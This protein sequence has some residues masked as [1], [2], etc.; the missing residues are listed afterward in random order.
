MRFEVVGHAANGVFGI[1][2]VDVTIPVKIYRVLL[3]GGRH[4]LAVAH[5]PGERPFQIERIVLFVSRHQQEGFQ[6]GRE[7]LG[8]ARVVEGER[9]QRI[10]DAGFTHNA[11]PAGLDPNNTDDDLRRH[12]IDLPRT[13]QGVF[14][15]IPEHHAILHVVRGNKLFAI[16]QPRAVWPGR[17][18]GCR[19]LPVHQAQH[20]VQTL[21]LRQNGMQLLA[22]KTVLA[23][24]FI[25]ELFGRRVIREVAA[26]LHHIVLRLQQ[27]SSGRRARRWLSGFGLGFATTGGQENKRRQQRCI[28]TLEHVA[29]I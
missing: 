22:V 13:V 6:L 15:L 12:A 25:D 28:T 24:H 23:H 19:R 4:K 10:K 17:H 8:A 29:S 11:S 20:I 18:L 27:E 3:I 1:P 9:R 26:H 7:I 21:R 14:I 16:A 2:Q 5:C